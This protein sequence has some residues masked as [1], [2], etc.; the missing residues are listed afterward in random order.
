MSTYK[1]IWDDF[2]AW[3][4]E[5]IKPVYQHPIDRNTYDST[6]IFFEKL[7]AI[8][9]PFMP[10]VSEEIWHE[11]NKR[12]EGNDLIVSSWPVSS[13]V[14]NS[15]LENF[16]IASGII[17]EIRNFRQSKGVSPKEQ[18]ELKYSV[19]GNTQALDRFSNA[20]I[21]L[22]NLSAL[23]KVTEKPT[24]AFPFVVKQFECFIPLSD[25]IDKE[26]EKERLIKELDY[27]QGFMKSVAAKLSNER[28]VSNAKPEVVA[29][30]Q[31]KMNDAEARI[32]AIEEA[33]STL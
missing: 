18:V 16:T 12:S 5:L 23:E 21:K 13:A 6:I 24:G 29:A 19:D 14:D 25:S 27:T 3:Y 11:L 33:L 26:A 10:F 17:T 15:I 9:H 1:L 31:K 30:E 32:K 8:L 22:A 4:L 7:M 2:C 28:F 20:I